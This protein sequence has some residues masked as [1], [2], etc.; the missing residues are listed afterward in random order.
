MEG[1]RKKQINLVKF[2][3]RFVRFV[4]GEICGGEFL[5]HYDVMEAVPAKLDPRKPARHRFGDAV[6]AGHGSAGHVHAKLGFSG[7]ATTLRDVGAVFQQ[8]QRGRR[9]TLRPVAKFQFFGNEDFECQVCRSP[10]HFPGFSPASKVC[11]KLFGERATEVWRQ[12]VR[13]PGRL[14][15]SNVQQMVHPGQAHH[16]IV[17]TFVEPSVVGEMITDQRHG[18]NGTLDWSGRGE[19]RKACA[20]SQQM[21]TT[22][23]HQRNSAPF[24]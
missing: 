7:G 1:R 24:A 8:E 17:L 3:P 11:Q 5:G 10:G 19:R 22:V 18:L 21:L 6:E 20:G 14:L 4:D 12:K 9:L 13:R 2:G 15:C 16:Q 23:S